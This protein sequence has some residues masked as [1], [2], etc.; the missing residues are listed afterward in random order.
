M[1]DR[2][3]FEAAMRHPRYPRSSAYCPKWVF[4]NSMG[5]PINLWLAEELAARM[6][7]LPGQR[8]LDLGCGSAT[9]SIFLGREFGVEVWAADLWIDPHANRQRI[10][11][12]GLD[13]SVFALSAEAHRLPF[14]R[15]FFDAIVSI[16]A[17]HYFGTEVRYLSYLSQFLRPGGRI[18]IV[19]PANGVDPD[20]PG[21]EP[22]KAGPAAEIGADWY[23]FRSPRWWWR[24]WSRTPAVAVELAEMIEGGLDDWRQTLDA[25]TALYGALPALAELDARLLEDEAAQALGFCLVVASRRPDAPSPFFGPDEF[26]TRIA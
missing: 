8:V 13:K 22:P 19:V 4:S 6:D 1:Q 2:E 23:T 16:D 15:G 9:S 21:S 26:E 10:V 14:A 20:D 11:E 18:G 17:Y 5:G 24:H 7:F 12:A 25:A 3:A